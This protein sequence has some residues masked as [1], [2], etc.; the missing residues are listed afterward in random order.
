[1]EGAVH[2]GDAWVLSMNQIKRLF[3]KH[4]YLL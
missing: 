1:M 4:N 2:T 3:L